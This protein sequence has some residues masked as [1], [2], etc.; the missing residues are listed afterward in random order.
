MNPNTFSLAYVKTFV[1]NNFWLNCKNITFKHQQ[2]FS[3]L[4]TLYD[5]MD[6]LLMP[7]ISCWLEVATSMMH[8]KK[9]HKC[10]SETH[11]AMF[12][13]LCRT[14]PKIS[15]WTTGTWIGHQNISQ[16]FKLT[17][18]HFSFHY[19]NCPLARWS[20]EEHSYQD[21]Q[22]KKNIHLNLWTFVLRMFIKI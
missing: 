21:H 5:S 14:L 6:K 12:F 18:F 1:R 9:N 15:I 10:F 8:M 22:N 11:R 17:S 20:V 13:Q 2:A 4:L 19:R 7:S 3:L 16:S